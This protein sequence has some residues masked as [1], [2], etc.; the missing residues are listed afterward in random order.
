MA[1]RR[2]VHFLATA[3]M[4]AAL[5]VPAMGYVAWFTHVSFLETVTK[6]VLKLLPRAMGS[7]I[8]NNRYD[9]LRGMTFMDRDIR[10]N[11]RKMLDLEEIRKE[12]YARLSRDIPYCVAALKD[13]EIKLDTSAG[14]IAG[15]LGMIAYSIILQKMPAFPDYIY[16][17]GFSRTLDSVIAENVIDVWVYYDGY[18]DFNSLGELMER[19]KENGMPRFIYMRNEKYAIRMREDPY[20]MFRAPQ[21]FLPRMVV[22]D[23]DANDV[24]N[25]ALNG[26]LDAYVYI[27]KCSGMDLAHPSY[28]A[29]PGTVVSRPS[30]RRT[31]TG[32]ILA[33]TSQVGPAAAAE[34]PPSA[35]KIEGEELVPEFE[36]EPEL[37]EEPPAPRV[38]TPPR[39]PVQTR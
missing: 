37:E 7:F 22:T 23:V 16:L 33:K 32:G 6:D 9:F 12:A 2:L 36:A 20:A 10:S 35:K 39:R 28:A 1:S 17:E 26:I 31:V 15:R 29:P 38:K 13:G 8:Y 30:R 19:L 25:E 21:K 11:P 24:Y 34:R 27:W 4:V 3:V 14:N 5:T 18:G